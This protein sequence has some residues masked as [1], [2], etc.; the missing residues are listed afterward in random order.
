MSTNS[1]ENLYKL[2]ER[3]I[4]KIKGKKLKCLSNS[5]HEASSF[6]CSCDNF[7]CD[8][9][10]KSHEKN[11]EIIKLDSK[12]NETKKKLDRYKELS[13][14][15]NDFNT[16]KFKKIEIDTNITKTSINKMDELINKLKE[17]KKNMIKSFELRISLVK[18]YNKEKEKDQ[19][20]Q[21]QNNQIKFE[22]LK[23]DELSDI[24]KNINNIKE[25]QETGKYLVQFYKLLENNIKINE[26]NLPYSDYDKI[27]KKTNELNNIIVEQTKKIY[28]SCNGFFPIIDKKFS[29]TD[30]IFSKIICKNL[31]I[32]TN[33][34]NNQMRMLNIKVEVDSMKKDKEEET[35]DNELIYKTQIFKK[36]KNN[37]NPEE[38]K[39]NTKVVEKI[40]EKPVE[41]IVE[42]PVE[43]IVEKIVEKPV[44]KIVEKI[45]EK[46]VEK[47]VE[48]VVEKPVE[49][50][51]EKI[52][53]KPV[54]KI[55]EKIVEKPVEKIVEK[56]V[57]K[58]VEKVVEKPM[59]KI[60][61]KPVE[62]TVE[63]II[64][65]YKFLKNQL[66]IDN[67]VSSFN[68]EGSLN[69]NDD[70]NNNNII[71]Q[72]EEIDNDNN[73]NNENKEENL[74][75]N[76][77]NLNINDVI[78]NDNDN[79]NNNIINS[80]SIK[81]K[82]LNNSS[83]FIDSFEVF[84]SEKCEEFINSGVVGNDFFNE[85][86]TIKDL[87]S[88]EIAVIKESK[89]NLEKESQIQKYTKTCLHKIN[90]L[91]KKITILS[92]PKSIIK[93]EL[94]IFS[95][96]E[97]NLI[98]IIS[99]KKDSNSLNIFNPYMNELEEILI[100]EKYKFSKNFAY[101][102]LLPYCYITGG[103]KIDEN[104]EKLE[105]SQFFAIRRNENKLFEFVNLPEMIE[106]KSNHC[107]VEL[108]YLNGIGVIG[109]TDTNDCEVFSFKKN[110]WESLPDLNNIRENSSCCILND[111]YLYCFFGYDNKECK[112]Q[113]SI[114][115]LNLKSKESWE[116]ITPT[117]PK[118]H[119]KRKASS[120]LYY[121]L[122]DKNYI[123]IV[124]GINSLKNECDDCLIYNEKENKIERI[125][126]ALPFKCSFVQN[127]YNILCSGYFANFTVD[128]MIIQ[129]QQ[130]GQIFFG[131]RKEN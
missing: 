58:P 37:I 35:G 8:E 114:E 30:F 101:I 82:E 55:V 72:K 104:G 111:K 106:S 128:S 40:V 109:G 107:M 22:E 57:E 93:K 115:K 43:K 17:I 1:A 44:E 52:V 36:K 117:G 81:K 10:I 41:K 94:K 15:F 5:S 84:T 2:L 89:N 18:K 9:C 7:I 103:I 25:E 118:V 121:N 27:N 73:D 26:K 120:C 88:N 100:P 122:K 46:P 4:T 14:V 59:E 124:G 67:R 54:E 113:D 66:I 105:L 38:N 34:Y 110:K 20:E 63:K 16:G 53:E 50:I 130:N 119:M 70:D 95:Q 13:S 39:T 62:K 92:T 48:K 45:V 83:I 123:L 61:E 99:P 127:S 116:V 97:M 69:D 32:S 75:D 80:K 33:E 91:K 3:E 112:F 102:N 86:K 42:K 78:Q 68:I 28:K 79:K 19:N 77:N 21:I 126:N 98:E 125:N 56:I 29:E 23:T 49:K 129:Y 24:D 71:E 87:K 31:N 47:I 65:K 85:I 76:N 108:K 74:N 64:T 90:E 12:F 51:V 11:H 60:V 6:C 96:K 131:I